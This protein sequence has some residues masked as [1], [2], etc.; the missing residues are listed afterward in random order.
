MPATDNTDSIPGETMTETAHPGA[1]PG[2]D[3]PLDGV[4]IAVN[5]IDIELM[6]ISRITNPL[7]RE[8]EAGAATEQVRNAMND[9]LARSTAIRSG[10]VLGLRESHKSWREVGELIGCSATVAY[11]IGKY[12][13]AGGRR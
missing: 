3:A 13:R 12:G 10:A 11:R 7:T 6:R 1:P 5:A 8:R 9:L 2:A 4:R